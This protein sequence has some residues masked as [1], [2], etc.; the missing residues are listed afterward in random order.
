MVALFV[1]SGHQRY[2]YKLEL[3][4]LSSTT[5]KRLFSRGEIKC[6]TLPEQVPSDSFR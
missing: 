6:E 2:I 1:Y 3:S 5:V 4:Y